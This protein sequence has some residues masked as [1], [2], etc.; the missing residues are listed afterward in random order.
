MRGALIGPSGRQYAPD[1]F[2][3]KADA[4]RWLALAEADLS[5][6]AWIDD[7]AASVTFGEYARAVLRNSPKIGVRWG[8]TCERNLRPHLAPLLDVPL[9]ALS[10]R[11]VREWNAAALRGTGGRTSIAQSYRF[12]RMVMNTAVR[13]GLV[14]GNPCRIPGAGVVQSGERPV[15]SPAQVVALVEAMK[16][17]VPYGG[18]DRRVVRPASR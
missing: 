2:R 10:Q 18:P 11:R 17:A 7:R 3:A 4:N 13:E 5:R 12:M 9:R 8:E 6:G 15:A 14:A 16:S 1:T